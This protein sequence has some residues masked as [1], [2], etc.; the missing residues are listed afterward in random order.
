MAAVRELF[1]AAS[2]AARRLI[3]SDEV[4]ARWDEPSALRGYA[5]AGLAG[6][7]GRAVLT[8]QRYL[9]AP[10]PPVEDAVDD[11]AGYFVAVLGDHDP[12]DSELHRSIRARSQEVAEPGPAAL[13]RQLAAAQRDLEDRF[14]AEGPDRRVT[15]RDGMVLPLEEYLATRLVELVVHLDDLAVSVDREPEALP[16][17]TYDVVAAVLARIAV[18][19]VGGLAAVRSLTRA[20]RQPDAVRAL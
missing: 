3:D 13:A 8:V 11:A 20:E 9:D 18:R 16:A 6:H 5:V 1:V 19:R 7:L 12:V 15:V 2:D 14:D 17:E 10:E 4:A